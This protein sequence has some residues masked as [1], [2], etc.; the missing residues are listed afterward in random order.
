VRPPASLCCSYFLEESTTRTC[1]M[2][3]GDPYNGTRVRLEKSKT[4]KRDPTA[5][6]M[7]VTWPNEMPELG[8]GFVREKIF[9]TSME[10]CP[11]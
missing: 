4:C 2:S 11:H 8:S 1:M 6:N 3:L 10:S 5:C 7:H 9:V